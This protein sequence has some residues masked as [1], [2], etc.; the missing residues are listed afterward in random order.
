M[1]LKREY[2]SARYNATSP[3]GSGNKNSGGGGAANGNPYADFNMNYQAR[4]SRTYTY[5]A[6]QNAGPGSAGQNYQRQGQQS[7]EQWRKDQEPEDDYN[8]FYRDAREESTQGGSSSSAHHDFSRSGFGNESAQGSQQYRTYGSHAAGQKKVEQ[9]SL[10]LLVAYSLAGMMALQFGLLL[11]TGG[12][13]P[14][15]RAKKN[16]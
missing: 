10:G 3:P 13:A 15:E 12:G 5:R 14:G 9:G 7:Y 16:Q 11:V 6:G 1:N 2:D 4:E 8:Y